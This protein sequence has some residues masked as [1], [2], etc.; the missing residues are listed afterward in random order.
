VNKFCNI[1]QEDLSFEKKKNLVAEMKKLNHQ[2]LSE[3]VDVID[4]VL[5]FL[6]SAGGEPYK[7]IYI[8]VT[9]TLAMQ[10]KLPKVV[11]R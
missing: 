11:I 5:R 3:V 7:T 1:F 2:K 10:K 6:A 9:K 4:I 8:Y